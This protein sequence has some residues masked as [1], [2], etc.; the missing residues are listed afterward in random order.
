MIGYV[1]KSD[2][3]ETRRACLR[4]VASV[5]VLWTG[6]AV[7]TFYAGIHYAPFFVAKD[8]KPPYGVVDL[9][10]VMAVITSVVLVVEAFLRNA[11]ASCIL[12]RHLDSGAILRLD[13]D[14]ARVRRRQGKD[15]QM[16]KVTNMERYLMQQARNDYWTAY[17]AQ[18][19]FC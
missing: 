13:A 3:D 11:L 15:G 17:K 2:N 9:I 10:F 4:F 6:F 14:V 8:A 5:G 16:M 18:R 7:F 12:A 1:S 19:G